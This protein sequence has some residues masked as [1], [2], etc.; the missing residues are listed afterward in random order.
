MEELKQELINNLEECIN[1]FETTGALPSSNMEKD[2]SMLRWLQSDQENQKY[3][4]FMVLNYFVPKYGK[5]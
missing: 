3:I 2:Y 4:S 5:K 1:T